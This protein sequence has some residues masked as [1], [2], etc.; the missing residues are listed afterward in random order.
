MA[1]PSSLVSFDGINCNIYSP[2]DTYAFYRKKEKLILECTSI[3]TRDTI[4][5]KGEILDEDAVHLHS[6]EHVTELY[7]LQ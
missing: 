7:R 4:P 1:Q 3:L 2:K 6:G 5:F